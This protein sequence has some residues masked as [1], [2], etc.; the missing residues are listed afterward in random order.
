VRF[1]LGTGRLDGPWVTCCMSLDGTDCRI[2]EPRPFDCAWYSHKFK[3]PGL[4]YEVAVSIHNGWIVWVNGPFACGSFPDLRIARGGIQRRMDHG[5]K[6]I[7]DGGYRDGGRFGL[8]PTGYNN[9]QEQLFAMIRARHETIN[10]RIKSWGAL[11]RTF[12]HSLDLHGQVFRSIA[13]IVQVTM[14]EETAPFQVQ[15]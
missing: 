8:T 15:Y 9:Y 6:Y 2:Q 10:S 1:N 13:N 11:G 5:E 4:R 3:G 14:E 12:R 7:A